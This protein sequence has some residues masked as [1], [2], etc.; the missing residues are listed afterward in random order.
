MLRPQ[1]VQQPS[2]I[3][4]QSAGFGSLATHQRMNSSSNANNNAGGG[5]VMLDLAQLKMAMSTKNQQQYVPLGTIE[6]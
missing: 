6:E 5:T 3:K 4:P 2:T 1:F